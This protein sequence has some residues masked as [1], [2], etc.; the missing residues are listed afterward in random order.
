MSTLQR[1]RKRPDQAV[2]AIRLTLDTPGLHYNK[3]GAEQHCKPG[4]WLVDNGGDVYSID[5]DSFKKT[6][7]KIEPGRYRKTTPVWAEKAH[8]DGRIKTK[9]GESEYQAGDFIVF[10]HPDRTDGYP[11]A[12]TLFLAM[13]EPDE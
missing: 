11:V 10:N 5:A 9:E 8:T 1:Y 7:Q 2:T 13:Y 12:E 4:D 3:W 6:Y